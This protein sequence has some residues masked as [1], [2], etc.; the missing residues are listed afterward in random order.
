[1]PYCCSESPVRRW[2]TI[3]VDIGAA[4]SMLLELLL[5]NKLMYEYCAGRTV[6]RSNRNFEKSDISRINNSHLASVRNF[7]YI[8]SCTW[9]D[10][11]VCALAMTVTLQH[12]FA[13]S[14]TSMRCFAR[15]L[16]SPYCDRTATLG[17][18]RFDTS[19]PQLCV[20]SCLQLLRSFCHSCGL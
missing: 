11:R 6:L 8:L 17:K 15:F 1:M 7:A 20:L 5:R 19:E 9:Y 10:L 18:I 4:S 14:G 13:V 3:S 2:E 16:G 12:V